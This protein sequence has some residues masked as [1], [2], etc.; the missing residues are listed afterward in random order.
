M[1]LLFL[2]EQTKAQAKLN[3]I[4]AGIRCC[5]P[6]VRNVHVADFRADVVLT[7]QEVE[8]H[9]AA[10]RE[11]DMGSSFGH[12]VI[13]KESAAA[14][15]EIWNHAAVRVQ[16]P[17]EGEWVYAN[18][19]GGVRF[20]NHQKDRD[21]VHRIFQAAAQETG[22]VRRGEDQAVTKT[23]VPDA[24]ARLAT[25]DPVAPAGPELQFMTALNR[26]GLRANCRRIKEYGED[27]GREY[28]CHR[29]FSF[30]FFDSSR[31]DLVQKR[32][33]KF[34]RKATVFHFI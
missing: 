26:A 2:A 13:A 21:G 23:Y 15:F 7:A 11:I 6:R 14:K 20:L 34:G 25:V 8:S 27:Q 10:A 28:S 18:A 32:Y 5:K 19:V 1:L 3:G 22:S 24:V 12:L 31:W 33:R 17:F 9:G 29:S 16:R 4:D 30:G